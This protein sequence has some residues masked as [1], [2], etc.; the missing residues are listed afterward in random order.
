MEALKG[1]RD[2]VLGMVVRGLISA[3]KDSGA[4][5]ELQL[6][7]LDGETR[8]GVEH[9]QTYGITSNPPAGTE[10]VAIAV[11]GN[12]DHLLV[13]ATGGPDRPTG[14]LPGEVALYG[15]TGILAL[16][17]ADGKLLLGGDDAADPVA[18]K[19]DL[20]ALASAFNG[21]THAAGS[22][23]ANTSTGAITG[24]TA[25]GPSHTA[26]GSTVVLAK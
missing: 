8:D 15:P 26:T 17:R 5:Q 20:Q 7:L 22:L 19:S 16:L 18:R 2:R 12:R 3:A 25:S 14:L 21:H 24:V 13:I 1:I 4:I 6:A 9:I 23:V 11:G 10:A